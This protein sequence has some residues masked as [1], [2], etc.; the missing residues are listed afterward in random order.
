[1]KFVIHFGTVRY[2]LDKRNCIFVLGVGKCRENWMFISSRIRIKEYNRFSNIR[3]TKPNHNIL[4]QCTSETHPSLQVTALSRTWPSFI[5]YNWKS[6]FVAQKSNREN[7]RRIMLVCTYTFE[8]CQSFLYVG[9]TMMI[10]IFGFI[11]NKA[12]CSFPPFHR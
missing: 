1:M 8:A 10:L 6:A 4:L 7:V 5:T 9:S 11:L 3:C 12:L 2:N